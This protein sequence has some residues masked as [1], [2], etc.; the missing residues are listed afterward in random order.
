M[1]YPLLKSQKW[2][3]EWLA[4]YLN[5]DIRPEAR[6][7]VLRLI[8]CL[9]ALQKERKAIVS[10]KRHIQNWGGGIKFCYWFQDKKV[11]PLFKE[12]N[13]LLSRYHF[14]WQLPLSFHFLPDG[15]ASPMQ[16]EAQRVRSDRPNKLAGINL[17]KLQ[18]SETT[19]A[20]N[21]LRLVE[22]D[23]LGFL[24]RCL[25]C[26]NWYMAH[27][28]DQAYCGFACGKQAYKRRNAE[29][30]REYVRKSRRRDAIQERLGILTLDLKSV[31]PH[32]KQIQSEIAKLNAE[33]QSLL[34]R[35]QGE[36]HAKN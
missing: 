33:Y 22:A 10:A 34:T 12:A 29:K 26:G 30:N 28:D 13:R 7:R 31:P 14:Y 8:V 6:K 9:D 11:A 5:A 21:I 2:G 23:A 16:A 35:K 15:K 19:A 36:Q 25:G 20:T 3:G 32:R 18:T 27:R 1:N 4:R 17:Q 24:R